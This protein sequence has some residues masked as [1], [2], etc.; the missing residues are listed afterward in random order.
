MPPASK[1]TPVVG[2]VHCCVHVGA[3]NLNTWLGA[4]TCRTNVPMQRCTITD[5]STRPK[6]EAKAMLLT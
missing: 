6:V 5:T 3:D 4:V 2:S 1:A